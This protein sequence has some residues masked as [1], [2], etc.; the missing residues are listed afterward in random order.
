MNQEAEENINQL[1]QSF[2]KVLMTHNH[3]LFSCIAHDDFIQTIESGSPPYDDEGYTKKSHILSL[4]KGEALDNMFVYK[5][6]E[7]VEKNINIFGNT[8]TVL[9]TML[10]D[11]WPSPFDVKGLA[12]SKRSVR[13]FIVLSQTDSGEWKMLHVYQA[14]PCVDEPLSLVEQ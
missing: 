14:L 9:V 13:L 4:L 11:I 2:A 1:L 12:F 7:F 5:N 6:T 10:S 3:E 8:A